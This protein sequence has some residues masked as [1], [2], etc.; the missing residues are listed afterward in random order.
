VTPIPP[1]FAPGSDVG[2]SRE[3]WLLHEA[4]LRGFASSASVGAQHRADALRQL[5]TAAKEASVPNWD[6]EG[7]HPVEQSTLRYATR[8][9]VGLPQGVASPTILVDR[10]GDIVFDWGP[11]PRSTFSVSI[12]RDGMLAY[13]GLFG[14]ARMLG[15]ESLAEGFPATILAG[16]DRAG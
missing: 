14:R 4:R 1:G 3:A 8:L 5:E 2:V 10:D 15:G 13:A 6:G 9:L 12:A 16:I 11:H 7:A